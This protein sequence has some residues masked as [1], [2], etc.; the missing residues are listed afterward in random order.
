VTILSCC[1][2]FGCQHLR[3]HFVIF[4][5]ICTKIRNCSKKPT[6]KNGQRHNTYMKKQTKLHWSMDT[7][8]KPK[9]RGFLAFLKHSPFLYGLKIPVEKRQHAT[10]LF[11]LYH[12]NRHQHY[13]GVAGLPRL[14]ALS[15]LPILSIQV[16]QLCW[17]PPNTNPVS[18]FT[19]IR[20]LKPTKSP[21]TGI[22]NS[23]IHLGVMSTGLTS[24]STLYRSR[25]SHGGW[26]LVK[27]T[28]YITEANC[29]Y[30]TD[31]NFNDLQCHQQSPK[32]LR[33]IYKCKRKQ[34]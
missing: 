16:P 18:Q 22:Q 3:R 21:T 5:H 12:Y 34:S 26:G 27:Y 4:N 31:N 25:R 28:S 11:F 2:F 10:Q 9:T 24:H 19:P 23:K 15:E 14:P 30:N 32:Y 6:S 20:L 17:L 8:G 33:H 13:L 29:I 7:F 1:F